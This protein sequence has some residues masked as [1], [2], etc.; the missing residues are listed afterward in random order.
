MEE[1]TIE[2]EVEEKEKEIL[3]DYEYKLAQFKDITTML[4]YILEDYSES[5]IDKQN[6]L[7]YKAN[8][9]DRMKNY[10]QNLHQ[11]LYD[12]QEEMKKNIDDYYSK[13]R[14]AKNNS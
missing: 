3:S 8:Y 6:E 9:Y 14:K 13:R 10:L 11:L 4:W 7:Y 1:K 12:R 5:S 2:I